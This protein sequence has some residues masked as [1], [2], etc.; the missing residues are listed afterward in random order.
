MSAAARLCDLHAAA[1]YRRIAAMFVDRP[2]D[3]RRHVCWARSALRR[4]HKAPKVRL[5]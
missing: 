3:F 4:A 5:P 1:S 2:T